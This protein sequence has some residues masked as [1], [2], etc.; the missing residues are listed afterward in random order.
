MVD[1]NIKRHLCKLSCITHFIFFE[2]SEIPKQMLVSMKYL[3]TVCVTYNPLTLEKK[4]FVCVRM[5]MALT[6]FIAF[7]FWQNMI[8]FSGVM[9]E[10]FSQ[11]LNTVCSSKHN[12]FRFST[13]IY[14]ATKFAWNLHICLQTFNNNSI[15]FVH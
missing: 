11:Q 4:V 15:Q 10:Y 7:A 14:F 8:L 3:N 1:A 9:F 5:I 2:I 12:H 13:S 6:N